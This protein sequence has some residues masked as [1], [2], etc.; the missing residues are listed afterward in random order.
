M[1]NKQFRQF[2]ELKEEF[3][4]QVIPSL[5]RANENYIDIHSNNTFIDKLRHNLETK[6]TEATHQ[7]N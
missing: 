5:N 6:L 3:Q 2:D 1:A 4:Q 7:Y